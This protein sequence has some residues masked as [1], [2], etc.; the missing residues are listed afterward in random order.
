MRDFYETLGVPRNADAGD[1]KKAYRKLAQRYHPDKNPDDKAAEEKFK[2]I[3]AAYET[4]SDTEKRRAYDQFGAAGG[5]TGG[6]FDPGAFRDFAGAR[7]VDLS[8]LLSDL[9]GRVRGGGASGPRM[10]PERG[11]DLQTS[12]NLSFDDALAGAQLTIPVERDVTC[13]ACHGTRAAPGTSPVTCPDCKGRGVRSRN[14]G[15]FALS[16]PCLRCGGTGAI[17]ETPCTECH[18]RGRI[19]RMKRYTV[20]IPAGVKDGARIRLPGRGGDGANGGP[21]GDLFVVVN[22]SASNL[23]ERRGDDFLVE[24]PI[25]FP[26][27]ALGG[28]IEVPTPSRERVRVKVPAGSGDGKTLRVKGRGAPVSNGDRRGDLLVRLKIIVP[29]KLT[30]QQREALE[31]YAVLDGGV[32]VRSGLFV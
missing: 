4:L 1:I 24:V 15:F 10:A 9:F 27:A 29:D 31:R 11:V 32:D 21:P 13:P 17:V 19:P 20:R 3:T 18:G 8:D 26:E 12:V 25:T 28:E 6:G 14:Q 5:M 2:E 30:R 22:V 16:E 7:G 23:F